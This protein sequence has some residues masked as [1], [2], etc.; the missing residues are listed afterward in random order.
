MT[1]RYS[2]EKMTNSEI[3]AL[4][5]FSLHSAPTPEVTCNHGSLIIYLKA[6]NPRIQHYLRNYRR[7]LAFEPQT[8]CP[9]STA[10]KPPLRLATQSHDDSESSDESDSGSASGDEA[11]GDS[12]AVPSPTEQQTAGSD[13]CDDQALPPTQIKS[14]G[15]K[16]K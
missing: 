10:V 16:S 3:Y 6:A 7:M 11:N 8:T 4:P 13:K 1:C 2:E 12:K 14:L 15:P 9:T 5:L